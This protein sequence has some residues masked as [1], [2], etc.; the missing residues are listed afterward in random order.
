VWW[1]VDVW[2]ATQGPHLLGINR[3]LALNLLSLRAELRTLYELSA[4]T[5]SPP[6]VSPNPRERTDTAKKNDY[7]FIPFDTPA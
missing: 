2:A 5:S 4:K 3:K 7:I 1:G 6:K